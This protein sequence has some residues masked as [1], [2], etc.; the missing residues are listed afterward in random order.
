MGNFPMDNCFTPNHPSISSGTWGCFQ[1]HKK[2][3]CEGFSNDFDYLLVCECDCYVT[4]SPQRFIEAVN[5]WGRKMVETNM[6]ALFIGG[7]S[8]FRKAGKG[9]YRNDFFFS[10][11]SVDA[12]C[13]L[14][15]MKTLSN[16]VRL[17]ETEKWWPFDLWLSRLLKEKL[18]ITKA[19]F[20]SQIEGKSLID[21]EVKGIDSRRLRL[22]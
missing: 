5:V 17:F 14:Y 6:W 16:I 13:V 7:F 15:P 19:K 21:G 12:H 10:Q 8:G 22:V 3:V 11:Q 18:A 4:V 1:A 2:A 9:V 20:A